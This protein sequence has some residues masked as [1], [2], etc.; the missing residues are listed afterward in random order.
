[1]TDAGPPDPVETCARIAEAAVDRLGGL[2]HQAGGWSDF[3]LEPGCSTS[4]VTAYTTVA[5]ARA[6]RRGS[7]LAAEARASAAETAERAGARLAATARHG[8]WGWAEGLRADADSTAWAARALLATGRPVEAAT[9]QFLDRHRGPAGYRTYAAAATGSWTRATPEVTAAVLLARHEGGRLPPTELLAGWRALGAVAPWTSHWWPGPWHPAALVLEL[10]GA[11]GRPGPRPEPPAEHGDPPASTAELADRL[12]VAALLEAP[13]LALPD[14]LLARMLPGGGWAGDTIVLVPA[15][16]QDRPALP[17]HDARGVFTTATVLH[18]AL[19]AIERAAPAD[20]PRQHSQPSRGGR[21]GRRR[22]AAHPVEDSARDDRWDAV[23]ARAA[24]AGGVP[25]AAGLAAFRSLTAESLA[26]GSPW[27]SPQLSSLASGHPVE[28]SAGPLPGLRLTTEVGDPRLPPAARVRSGLAAVGRTA[29]LLGV[30]RAWEGPAG[31]IVDSLVDPDLPVPDGCRFWLW[32]GVDLS[33][34]GPAVLKAYLSLHAGDVDGWP[35]RLVEALAPLPTAGSATRAR[36]IL[37][38]AGWC[39]EVGI[40]VGAAGRWGLKVYYELD[41]WRPD[42][43]AALLRG[44]HLPGSLADVTADIPGVVRA[45][46]AGR[47][48][49]GIA[50]R[51]DPTSGDVVELTTALAMPPALVSRRELAG[52]VV[53]WVAGRGQDPGPL[54]ALLVAVE[55][56]WVDAGPGLRQLGLV[57]LSTGRRGTSATVYVRPGPGT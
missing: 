34:T 14:A 24:E 48:R 3:W 42:V 20:L 55:P 54:Q 41:R 51:V 4:W 32:A 12:W 33:A 28:L 35:A 26:A 36:E 13:D 9:W 15:Q 1:M 10:W 7:G 45:T 47:R 11:A 30:E 40:G 38:G 18:G 2:A 52:R 29:R 22:G 50:L 17:T 43:V 37:S 23:I 8:S 21:P 57:T 16:A 46:H 56:G 49:A 31:G 44:C 6:A 25:A 5:V 53:S 27:P 39:H 19:A